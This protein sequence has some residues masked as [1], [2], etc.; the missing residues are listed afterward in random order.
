MLRWSR[1]MARPLP[2]GEWT[3]R[4]Q[5]GVAGRGPFWEQRT[6]AGATAYAEWERIVN[7]AIYNV[8]AGFVGKASVVGGDAEV[9]RR[10]LATA[11]FF[12]NASAQYARARLGRVAG[13][14][15][16]PAVV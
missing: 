11:N 12:R 10:V 14:V 5:Q 9:T 3:R 4:F 7:P 8:V 6:I 1:K 15:P 2:V 16:V 13:A